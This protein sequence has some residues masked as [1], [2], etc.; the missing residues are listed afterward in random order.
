MVFVLN[1]LSAD[2]PNFSPC[3]N[4]MNANKAGSMGKECGL[5]SK[6]GPRRPFK[7]SYCVPAQIALSDIAQQNEIRDRR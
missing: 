5:G 7:F 3:A 4:L 6:A 2:S 1:G